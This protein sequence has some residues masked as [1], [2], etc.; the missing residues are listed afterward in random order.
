MGLLNSKPSSLHD[1]KAFTTPPCHANTRYVTHK[2]RG[3]RA[4][5]YDFQKYLTVNFE[6]YLADPMSHPLPLITFPHC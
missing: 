6:N 2:D 5:H 1:W 3:H 4:P